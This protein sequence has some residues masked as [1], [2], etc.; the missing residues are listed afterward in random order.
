[1]ITNDDMITLNFYEG[2]CTY[3]SYRTLTQ[4]LPYL[5]PILDV[6]F[7]NTLYDW[8]VY[9]D[10]EKTTN[11]Q[12]LQDR[13]KLYNCV[14]DFTAK[15]L[16]CTHELWFDIDR[17]PK[18]ILATR[19]KGENKSL[20]L[21]RIIKQAIAESRRSIR[22]NNKPC[23]IKHKI[24]IYKHGIETDVKNLLYAG[25]FIC[26]LEDYEYKILLSYFMKKGH[27]DKQEAWELYKKGIKDRMLDISLKTLNLQAA[28]GFMKND[29]IK[30]YWDNLFNCFYNYLSNHK[31]KI[32]MKDKNAN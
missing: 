27:L 16:L 12:L 19:K 11:T 15:Q 31:L 26:S 25:N 30:A 13:E 20:W 4:Y 32:Y 3:F 10:L 2:K 24:C 18:Y 29:D 8:L 7:E 22:Q 21:K 14:R 23:F 17:L 28:H 9:R 1:M 6:N 5:T